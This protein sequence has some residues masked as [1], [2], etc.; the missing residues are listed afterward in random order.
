M[1]Q[2]AAGLSMRLREKVYDK[3][4]SFTMEEIGG[5]WYEIELARLLYNFREITLTNSY[6]LTFQYKYGIIS[7][8]GNYTK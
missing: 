8:Y 4:M 3:V 7:V 1:A 6:I 2:I 5:F